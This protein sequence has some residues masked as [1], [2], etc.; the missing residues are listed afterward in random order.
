MLPELMT[1][2]KRCLCI[3]LFLFIGW[4]LLLLASVSALCTLDF[5]AFS[6]CIF[7]IWA[8]LSLATH[9]IWFCTWEDEYHRLVIH[10][11]YITGIEDTDPFSL[12]F[13]NAGSL[14]GF[15]LGVML[16]D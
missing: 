4:I 15:L 2:S 5:N 12:I 11:E 16:T 10:C 14:P 8:G 13:L 6:V 9:I 1:E 7:Q 3:A